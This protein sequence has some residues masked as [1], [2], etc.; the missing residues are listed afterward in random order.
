MGRVIAHMAERLGLPT[1]VAALVLSACGGGELSMTEY[2]DRVDVIFQRAI[3]RYEG[4]IAGPGG[5]VL[6]VGQG[7]HL[8]FEYQGLQLSDFTPQDLHVALEQVADIQAEAIEAA[9]AIDPPRQIA[10]I[11]ALYFRELPLEDL[12]ARAGTA[13][14]WEELS[15][16]PE[17]AAYRIALEADIQICD[18]F[19]A[20]LDATADRGVFEDVPWMPSELSEIVDY[21][22]GCGDQPANPQ[23][24]YRPPPT[25]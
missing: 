6:V 10:D 3:E 9:A 24:A 16:S 23:D 21:A 1:L 18:D 22:L 5:L 25:P 19:Q 17:M 14:D 7:E 4:V 12:A 8:G 15:E 13:S 20:T 11:H 2:V